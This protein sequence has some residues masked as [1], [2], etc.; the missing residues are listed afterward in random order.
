MK[1]QGK[2]KSGRACSGCACCRVVLDGGRS[3][4]RGNSLSNKR[5]EF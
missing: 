2:K 4:E 1:Q 5:Y 3:C